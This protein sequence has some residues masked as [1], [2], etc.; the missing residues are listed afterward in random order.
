M[1][2]MALTRGST[3]PG[4]LP[5][6]RAQDDLVAAFAGPD[7]AY[8]RARFDRLARNEAKPWEANWAAAVQGPVWAALR[9]NWPLFWIALIL[10]TVALMLIARGLFPPP[11]VEPG[12]SLLAGLLVLGIGRLAVGVLAD[13]LY[14]R[15]F[16]GWRVRRKGPSGVEASRLLKAGLA[17][18]LVT[19]LLVYRATQQAP[20]F[21]ECRRLW[22]EAADGTAAA[23]GDRFNCLFIGEVPIDR[24]TFHDPIAQAIDNGVRW[25]VVNLESFFDYITAGLRGLLQALE[26]V[27]IGTPWPVMFALMTLVAWRVAG[28]NVAIFV[29]AALVYLAVLGFW[30]KAM[31]TLSLVGA[32]TVICIVLGVPIGIWCAKRA[33][34]YAALRPVLDVMQT[35]P[36][37]VYLIPAIAFFGIGK[38][39][40]I[41]ATVIFALP[42]MVRLTVL[43]I[44]Q[45]PQ[46]V[47]EA[48]VAFGATPRQLLWKVELPLAVPSIMTGINQTIMMSLSMVV[49][50]ALIAASILLAPAIVLGFAVKAADREDRERGL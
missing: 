34:A 46:S 1:A 48:A 42:P 10:D 31:S 24:R 7:A 20:S 36:S 32:A 13:R 2:D 25:L 26:T 38:P 40:G 30:E 43:G 6:E 4:L 37:F 16:E 17:A 15:Q 29:A 33:R 8:F 44:E 9:G 12:R 47:K 35:L 28:R 23:L 45:V 21:R 18:L 19:P 41:I 39:P 5:V 11:D 3:D 14:R 22:R 27:F 49:V 50:A